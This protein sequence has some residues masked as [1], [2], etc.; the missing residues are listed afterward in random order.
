MEKTFSNREIL[1]EAVAM[2]RPKFWSII[3]QYFV[4]CFLLTFLFEI[5][6]GRG[7]FIGA[8]IVSYIAVKW[9]FAY[10]NKGSFSF[11][12]IFE[13]LTLKKFIYFVVAMF[14]V[15]LSVIGGFILVIIPGIIFAIRLA[16]VKYIIIDKETKPMQALRESKKITKGYRWKLFWFFLVILLINI[17]GIICLVVGVFYT[18]PLTALATVIA[19]KKL[20]GRASEEVVS[21]HPVEVIVEEVEV[22]QA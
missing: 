18:A 16:F 17:L 4:I 21:E 2:M 3:G 22:V 7:A 14:L 15:G 12:D 19:Y 10:V 8:L 5:L 11:D 20:S 6:F 13:G 9:A 1:K